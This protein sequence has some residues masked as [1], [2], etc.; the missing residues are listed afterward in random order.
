M[1]YWYVQR[2]IH[3]WPPIATAVIKLGHKTL[4]DDMINMFFILRLQ[5]L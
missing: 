2:G 3:I 5:W 4:Q 1:L